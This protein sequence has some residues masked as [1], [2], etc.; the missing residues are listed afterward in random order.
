MKCDICGAIYN[1]KTYT[2]SGECFSCFEGLVGTK[3][4]KVKKN[5]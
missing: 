2:G 3:S 4:K 5:G 1:K